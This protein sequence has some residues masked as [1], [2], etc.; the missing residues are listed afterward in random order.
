M[1][2]ELSASSSNTQVHFAGK[3]SEQ[4]LSLCMLAY[5]YTPL[6]KQLVT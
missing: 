6:S 4:P 2:I 3:G 5:A 1:R